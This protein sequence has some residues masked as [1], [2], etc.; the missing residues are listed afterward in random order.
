MS[1]LMCAS[2]LSSPISCGLI[3]WVR[4]FACSSGS[5]PASAIASCKTCQHGFGV[6][7]GARM[8]YQVAYWYS[9]PCEKPQSVP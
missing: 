1:L 4:I 5:L 2:N 7:P 6:L 9:T 3:A 8:P